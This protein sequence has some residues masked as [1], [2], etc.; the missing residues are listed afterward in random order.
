MAQSIVCYYFPKSSRSSKLYKQ[1]SQCLPFLSPLRHNSLEF[2][3]EIHRFQGSSVMANLRS[4][5]IYIQSLQ[6][7]EQDI[8]KVVC[9]LRTLFPTPFPDLS[10]P[11]LLCWPMGQHLVLRVLGLTF[12]K[13]SPI[14]HS[15]FCPKDRLV[16]FIR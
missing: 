15:L 3:L 14:G 1:P 11:C 9:G 13:F 8:G 5:P 12:S 4:L 10:G 2:G 16:K 6:A 7:Y